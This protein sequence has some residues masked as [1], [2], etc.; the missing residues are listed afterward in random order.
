MRQISVTN[1][2]RLIFDSMND[3]FRESVMPTIDS[4][5]AL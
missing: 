3:L 4:E 1:A 5:D 2:G